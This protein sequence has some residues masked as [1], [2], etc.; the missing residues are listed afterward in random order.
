V[1][2]A[3]TCAAGVHGGRLPY[4]QTVYREGIYGHIPPYHTHQGGHIR[5]IP[6]YH[7]P[8]REDTQGVVPPRCWSRGVHLSPLLIPGCTSLPLLPQGVVL[9]PL[10]PQGVVLLPLLIRGVD[11]FSRCWSRVLITLPLLPQGV[12]LSPVN[13]SGCGGILPW[14][15]F[16]WAGYSPVRFIPWGEIPAVLCP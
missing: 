3:G 15:L 13:T 11:L 9:L 6:P 5:H 10:L 1:L 7:T 12:G 16:L 8:P 14:G 4:L 2:T